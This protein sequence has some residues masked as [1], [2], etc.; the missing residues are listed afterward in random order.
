MATIDNYLQASVRDN[1]KRS[2]RFAIEHYEQVWG[3]FLPAT[4]DNIAKYLAEPHKAKF[5]IF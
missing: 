1:T 4:A 3:V 5:Y 2:Y